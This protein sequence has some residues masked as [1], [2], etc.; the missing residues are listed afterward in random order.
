MRIN[1]AAAGILA[2]TAIAPAQNGQQSDVRITG[3]VFKPRQLPPPDLK[4]LKVPQGFRVERFAENAGN[5]R[6]LAV[7]ADG[8]VYVTRREQSDV[9][10]FKVGADGRSAGAPRRVAG[11]AGLH[12]IAISGGKVYLA[13]VHEVYT[14]PILPDGSFGPLQMI[15]HDLPDAGQ[16]N[17]RTMQ[18]GPDNMLYIGIGSTCNECAEPNPENATLLRASLDGK[19]RSIFASG[20]RDTIGWGWHPQTGELWG[21]DHGIDWLGDDNQP[22]ELN[23]IEKGKRYG[24]PFVYGDNRVNPHADPPGGLS[25]EEWS[26]ASVPM[27]LGYT[28]HSAPMQMSFYTASQ[29]PAEYAGDAFVSMR[30]SWNRKP[31]SGYEIV[32]VRFREGQPTAIE[33]FLTGF[34]TESGE[35]GR[36]AG[37]AITKDGSLLFTDDRNG[38]IYR[39][40]YTGESGGRAISG[41]IPD[42][43]MLKQ[44]RS[45]ERSP[46]AIQNPLVKSGTKL[47][48]QS[49]AFGNGSS[50]PLIYSAY[51]Q[52]VSPALSWSKGPTATKSYVLLMEDPDAKTT[53]LPVIHWVA[54]NIL[55]DVTSL[56]EGLPGADQ[57]REPKGMRQGA[58]QSGAVGYRGPKPPQGD[59]PH[60]YHFQIFALDRELE[61]LPGATREDVLAAM[62]GR[63]LASGEL[64]GSFVRPSNPTKP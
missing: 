51:D 49:P 16:H 42:Q 27:V 6:M 19:S 35:H 50:I 40:S 58:N 37:N 60:T 61:L 32:R 30:G 36:L 59:P 52:N 29:F 64:Q 57:L 13:T 43:P 18:I 5:A 41:N 20:L 47:S 34:L 24:W 9:L 54:W 23:R 44:N 48:V 31:A 7:G 38:V 53:P 46:I 45:G 4:Q 39:V 12:G 62:K 56:P 22:E 26:R 33:P 14:A 10:L 17:T 8:S 2:I 55:A 1:Y 25:K 15:I 63:V 3:H 11:R 21:M 28:P